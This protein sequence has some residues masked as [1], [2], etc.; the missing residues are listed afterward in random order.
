[1]TYL[2]RIPLD[3]GGSILVEVPDTMDGPMEEGRVGDA[4]HDLPESLH[5]AL[6]SVAEA[7]R[8]MLDQLRKAGPDG[9]TVEFGVDLSVSAG[10]VITKTSTNGHLRVTMAWQKKSPEGPDAHSG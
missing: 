9:I 1:M 2:A 10:A 3:A 5:E 6:G 4:I 7:A 8:T